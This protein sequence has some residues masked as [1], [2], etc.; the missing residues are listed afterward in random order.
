MPAGITEAIPTG[1]ERRRTGAA[2]CVYAMA[3]EMPRDLLRQARRRA[4]LSASALAARAGVSTS[5][6]LRIESGAM[7]PT[8]TMLARLLEAAGERLRLSSDTEDTPVELARLTDAW[9]RTG[10]VD[11]PDWTKLRGAIDVL[12]QR[13]DLV[14]SAIARPPARSS[15]EVLDALLAGIADRLAD[16]QQLA[17]PTW[18][19]RRSLAA[20]WSPPGTP[21]QTAHRLARTPSQLKEHNVVVDAETLWRAPVPHA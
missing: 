2:R 21:R 9:R 3:V 17:R 11:L 18:T 10:G 14:A 15:S 5:T 7:D 4:A 6:V 8:V 16:D 12:R 20:L 13:P 19:K 1:C